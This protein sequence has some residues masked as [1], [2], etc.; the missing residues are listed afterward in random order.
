MARL[1]AEKAALARASAE[2]AERGA[3][4]AA[5]LQAVNQRLAEARAWATPCGLHVLY[6]QSSDSFG[7]LPLGLV[8]SS[9]TRASRALQT[10]GQL[11]RALADCIGAFT[12]EPL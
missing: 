7:A 8:T 5:T 11:N 12:Q 3:T 1:E 2:A 4:Q 9:T 10:K 6:V